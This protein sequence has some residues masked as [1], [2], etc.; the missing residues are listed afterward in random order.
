[1]NSVLGIDVHYNSV[2]GVPFMAQCVKNP[3][4]VGQ[5]ALKVQV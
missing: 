3:M 5:V 1:M 4:A 2:V